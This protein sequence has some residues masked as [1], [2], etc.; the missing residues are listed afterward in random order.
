M[1]YARVSTFDTEGV[2]GAYVG[3]GRFTEDTVDTFGGYGVAEI[4]NL[5]ELLRHVCENG[6]EHHVAMNH[7][8]CAAAVYEAF[9][10]YMDWD[11]YWHQG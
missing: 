1:T 8:A 4:P 2:I 3:E 6:F 9:D 7:S 5:Q 11:V 10:K